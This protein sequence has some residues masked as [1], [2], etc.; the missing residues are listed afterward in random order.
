[1]EKKIPDAVAILFP[2]FHP[3]LHIISKKI[4][5]WI[6]CILLGAYFLSD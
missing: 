3:P 4:L 5:I 1:M 2:K 6:I